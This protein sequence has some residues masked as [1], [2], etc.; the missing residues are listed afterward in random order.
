M[1]RDARSGAARGRLP[2]VAAIATAAIPAIASVVAVAVPSAES[3][4]AVVDIDGAVISRR[5]GTAVAAIA[6][7]STI[8]TVPATKCSDNDLLS[9]FRHRRHEHE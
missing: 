1:F 6:V 4:P 8:A 7:E 2:A 9:L 5:I 3:A